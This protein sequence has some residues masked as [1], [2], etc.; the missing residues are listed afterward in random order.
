MFMYLVVQP[1]TFHRSVFAR[2]PSTVMIGLMIRMLCEGMPIA[3]VVR[4]FSNLRDSQRAG[5]GAF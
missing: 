1:L 2:K 5:F 4:H 3:L